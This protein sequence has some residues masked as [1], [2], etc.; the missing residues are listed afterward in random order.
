MTALSTILAWGRS[1]AEYLVFGISSKSILHY[2]AYLVL[3]FALFY[4]V[5]LFVVRLLLGKLAEVSLEKRGDILGPLTGGTLFFT[6]MFQGWATVDL[7]FK[8]WHLLP[9]YGYD[10]ASGQVA[11]ICGTIAGIFVLLLADILVVLTAGI[12]GYC[13][14]IICRFIIKTAW[15]PVSWLWCKFE[16]YVNEKIGS[17]DK[18]SSS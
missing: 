13:L 10:P 12:V 1:R 8:H 15:F 7:L 17:I 16:T 9:R 6:A 5:Y 14:A 11:I 2:S 3:A 4:F 18:R